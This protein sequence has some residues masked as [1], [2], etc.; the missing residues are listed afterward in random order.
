MISIRFPY[1][2]VA[3][4]PPLSC[5]PVATNGGDHPEL[6]RAFAAACDL[7]TRIIRDT[8]KAIKADYEP[9][10][11]IDFD[12]PAISQLHRFG[13]VDPQDFFRFQMEMHVDRTHLSLRELY[14]AAS[15]DF[16]RGDIVVK[17]VKRYSLELHCFCYERGHA[18]KILGYQRLPGGWWGIAMESLRWARALDRPELVGEIRALVDAFH[19]EGLVHGDLRECNIICTDETW[20]VIDF[21]W[22]GIAGQVEYPH[23]NLTEDLLIGRSGRDDLKITV[24][25]DLAI[26]KRAL[27]RVVGTA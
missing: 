17:F 25:D 10:R 24:E 4:T 12:L 13:S 16:V 14:I 20:W 7:Q 3:L 21:D 11:I 15:R 6:Y 9:L 23:S 2:M 26:L 5:S 19:R 18:P 8:D 27:E 22:S 1:R